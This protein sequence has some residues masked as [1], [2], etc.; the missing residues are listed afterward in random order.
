MVCALFDMWGRDGEITAQRAPVCPFV[1]LCSCVGRA[2]DGD[3]WATL[4]WLVVTIAFLPNGQ[5]L[6]NGRAMTSR[7]LP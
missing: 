7:S 5:R 6:G 2:S 1:R 4:S 3:V